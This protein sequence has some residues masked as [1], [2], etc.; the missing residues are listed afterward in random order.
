[1]K[2]CRICNEEKPFS[3]FYVRGEKD[4]VPVYRNECRQCAVAKTKAR[5]FSNVE[6]SREYHRKH[7]AE[8]RQKDPERFKA[9]Y[10]KNK[11]RIALLNSESYKRHC[12]KRK[13]KVAEW[14]STN[15]GKSNAIKKAYKESK[16]KALLSWVAED[17]DFMWMIDECYELAALRSKVTGV[18]WHVDHIVPLRGKKVCGLHA[19]WN[20]QVITGQQNCSKS[21]K[22][23]VS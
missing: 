10:E 3:S 14:V 19:P 18:A 20:L 9:Y 7:H 13:A 21:N 15:R 22:F 1:M 12:E 8:L 23:E 11:Q 5:Y 17:Q 16:S 6:E 4:G 2:T